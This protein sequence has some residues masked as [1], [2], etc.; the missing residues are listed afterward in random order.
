MLL[1][2][3]I[4]KIQIMK[5]ILDEFVKCTIPNLQNTTGSIQTPSMLDLI[6][7]CNNAENF[8]IT[9]SSVSRTSTMEHTD[10]RFDWNLGDSR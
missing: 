5:Q 8:H 1:N 4:G 10:D 7:V 3:N 6:H 2:N 9:E